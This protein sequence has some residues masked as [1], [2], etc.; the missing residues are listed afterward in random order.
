MVVW[1]ES[2]KGVSQ[3]GLRVIDKDA[4]EFKAGVQSVLSGCA[5]AFFLLEFSL[6]GF[7]FSLFIG[8]G[9]CQV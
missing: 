3:I 9:L 4:S 6:K 1:L 8:G 7:F 2:E 5:L